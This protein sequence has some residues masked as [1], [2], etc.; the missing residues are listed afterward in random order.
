MPEA[1]YSQ[2]FDPF[3]HILDR[4]RDDDFFLARKMIVDRALGVCQF[5]GDPIH[6]EAVIAF[7]H[8]DRAGDGENSRLPLPDFLLLGRQFVHAF[9]Y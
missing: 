2:Q 1:S 9:H 3:R 7:V 6:A 5:F 8:H 4:Q